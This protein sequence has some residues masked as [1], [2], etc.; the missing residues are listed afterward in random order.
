MALEFSGQNDFDRRLAYHQQKGT[1][2]E[3]LFGKTR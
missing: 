3:F 2:H 1:D